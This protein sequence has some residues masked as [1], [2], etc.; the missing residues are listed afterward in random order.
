[1]TVL[2]YRPSL[3]FTSGA[4]QLMHMQLLAL[5]AAGIAAGIGCER[6]A[7]RFLLRS[8]TAARRLRAG[9]LRGASASGRVVVDHGL[10]VPD[11]ALVFVHNVAA[12]ANARLP[13]ADWLAASV[14]ERAFFREL[15]PATPVIANSQLAKAALARHFALD[16]SRIAVLYPG[17]RSQRF[18]PQRAAALRP[19]ARRAL[20]LGDAP[21]VGLV[22]SGDFAKRGLDV[23][24]AAADLIASERADVRFLVVGSKVLPSQA[25]EH[26]LV[27]SGRVAYR[28]KSRDPERWFAALDVFLY[29]ARFE[30]F[31]MVVSEAQAIGL[32]IVTSRAVGAAECLP[33]SYERWLAD[34]PDAADAAQRT[35]RLLAS[36]EL[37]RE[38]ASAG[39]ANAVRYDDRA[40]ASASVAAIERVRSGGSGRR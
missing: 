15:A 3:D 25:R 7:L 31:G 36:D 24:L 38:L 18:S 40:Y 4:G 8:G 32:P 22:T 6:G 30:E 34:A 2:L 28:P 35:L 27:V 17:Y 5:R 39:V 37:R 16:L 14:A 11:A 19:A 23:F 33:A 26:P 9:S 13:R 12:E 21:L 10:S 29:P 1:M 20:G